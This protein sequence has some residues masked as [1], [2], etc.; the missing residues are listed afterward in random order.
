MK[1]AVVFGLNSA[2]GMRGEKGIRKSVFKV[3]PRGRVHGP[4]RSVER[5]QGQFVP[6]HEH[7]PHCGRVRTVIMLLVCHE[8]KEDVSQCGNASGEAADATACAVTDAV[9]GTRP[10]ALDCADEKGAELRLTAN[11]GAKHR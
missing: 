3:V 8:I 9:G 2:G 5:H 1:V 10:I 6:T 4:R 11:G 7:A